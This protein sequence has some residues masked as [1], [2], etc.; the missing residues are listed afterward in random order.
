MGLMMTMLAVAAM[1]SLAACSNKKG[2]MADPASAGS[3]ESGNGMGGGSMGG[4]GGNGG[5]Y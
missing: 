2:P 4:S 5:G 1:L 3:S